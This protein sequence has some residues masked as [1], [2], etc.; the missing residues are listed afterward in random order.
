MRWTHLTVTLTHNANPGPRCGVPS[1][2]SASARPPSL[3][4]RGG[5][6]GGSCLWS[7]RKAVVQLAASNIPSS[8]LFT[9]Y[10]TSLSC[11][12]QRLVFK[13]RTATRGAFGTPRRRRVL[14]V[15]LRADDG[16]G[17]HGA[18]RVWLFARA[19]AG[20]LIKFPL[21]TLVLQMK[22]NSRFG[23]CE[24]AVCWVTRNKKKR[25]RSRSNPA[26]ALPAL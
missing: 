7:C 2:R 18:E 25:K 16:R 8:S 24:P 9:V 20:G 12:Y 6:R 22:Y 19:R 5:R 21:P 13:Y 4:R 11:C 17:A 10:S 15:Q 23:C 3:T 1:S 26:R 14:R